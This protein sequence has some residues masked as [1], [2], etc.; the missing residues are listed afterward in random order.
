[1][2]LIIYLFQVI[3]Y[4]RF[5]HGSIGKAI[6]LQDE[7]ANYEQ[8]D[9]ILNNF[10]QIDIIDMWN[11]STVFYQ[12]KDSIHNLLE[13]VNVVLLEKL[14]NTNDILY[15]NCIQIVEET[16]KRLSSNANYDMCIDNL[17]LKIWEEFHE[18]YS[19]S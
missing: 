1:M 5:V 13:Y 19:R 4:L 10:E 3:I 14:K 7:V 6:I 17:L 12:S 11:K 2:H 18:K 9:Y 16:K 15:A 8:I